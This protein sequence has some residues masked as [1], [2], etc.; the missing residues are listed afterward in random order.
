M[1]NMGPVSL[2]V[3]GRQVT[4]THPDKVVFE[5]H[6]GAGP[7][8]KLD[9][10]RYYLSVAEGALRGVA[11]RPMILKRFV[12]GISEEAVFQKRAP[13]NRPDWV[14]VAELRYAR[15]TS[16]AEAVIHDAAGLAWAVNL[17]CVDLNPHPVLAD[18]LDHPDELRVDLD[19]M[20]GVPW[21][22]IVDVALVA[23]E[24]LE[25]Y[26]LTAWP[27]TSGSRGFHIYARIAPRWEFRQVRLAAQTVAREVERRAPDAAT[28]RWWKEEREGVF[29]DFNQNAKDRTVASAYSVRATPDARV[30]TPLLWDEVTERLP[31]EFTIDTVPGR[32]AAMGDPWAGMDDAVGELDRLLVLAEE[33]GPP[34]RAPKGSGTSDGRRRSVMPLIE[35]ARTKTKDEALAALDTWRDRHPDA[36]R[37]LQP[38]DVLVDGMRG[39]SSIWYRIRINL[40]HV[41][42]GQRPPQEELIADYSPWE[43][44]GGK[45]KPSS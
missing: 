10:V 26:G 4:I 28:S 1:M 8:T 35:I 17:G 2:E 38:V 25:D 20:P 43:G 27:K 13:K 12:K 22:R 21:R 29:V 24:V 3:A 36:S 5:A 44:Y 15:G 34:E 14:D 19:P 6:G 33:M 31:E 30:S 11:G 18:D 16:A 39:P 37:L 9:L 42:V 41:P 45:Q 40:Q 23:R 32:F 7:H